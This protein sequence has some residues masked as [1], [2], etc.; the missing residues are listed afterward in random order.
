M[1]DQ[2]IQQALNSSE[3]VNELARFA[4][5]LLAEGQTREMVLGLFESARQQLRMEDRENQEDIVMDVM[6]F[7]VG[8][9]SPHMEFPHTESAAGRLDIS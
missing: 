4:R 8:W 7:I 2:R 5:R 9:C 6:D 3:P 1:T